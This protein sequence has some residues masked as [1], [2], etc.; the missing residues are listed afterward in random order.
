MIYDSD[1]IKDKARDMAKAAGLGV[2]ITEG[3]EFTTFELW[4]LFEQHASVASMIK[5][6]GYAWFRVNPLTDTADI[7]EEKFNKVAKTIRENS[8][9]KVTASV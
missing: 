1:C 2:S 3:K 5:N 9:V 6:V 4:C 7:F 8:L